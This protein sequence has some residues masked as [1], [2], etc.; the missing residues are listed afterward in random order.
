[1]SFEW[2]ADGAVRELG[3]CVL[4]GELRFGGC[5]DRGIR[6]EYPCGE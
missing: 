6:G 1:M 3:R 5:K 2:D 4:S